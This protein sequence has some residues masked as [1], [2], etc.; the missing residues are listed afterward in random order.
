MEQQIVIALFTIVVQC[1]LGPVVNQWLTQR[2][3]NKPKN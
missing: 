1:I 3:K 2:M